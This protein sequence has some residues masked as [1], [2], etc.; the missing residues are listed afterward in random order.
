MKNL[1]EDFLSL[2]K[3]EEGLIKANLVELAAKSLLM[4]YRKRSADWRFF[5]GKGKIFFLIT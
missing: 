3:L 1:L 2:G 4:K 5:A